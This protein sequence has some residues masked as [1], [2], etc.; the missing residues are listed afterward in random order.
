MAGAGAGVFKLHFK[1]AIDR[2][3]NGLAYLGRRHWA[4]GLPGPVPSPW[5]RDLGRISSIIRPTYIDAVDRAAE[6]FSPADTEQRPSLAR[7][8]QSRPIRRRDHSAFDER[9]PCAAIDR[10]RA[11]LPCLCPRLQANANVPDACLQ[12]A[13]VRA[14]RP[15]LKRHWIFARFN[16]PACRDTE[17][18]LGELFLPGPALMPFM[19]AFLGARSKLSS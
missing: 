3:R 17:M 10:P 9:T 15:C 13:L 7:H 11:C 6:I 16:S 5:E 19:A 12:V 2:R 8:H 14:E 1:K 4:R 18:G